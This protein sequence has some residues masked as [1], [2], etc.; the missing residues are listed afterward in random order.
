MDQRLGPFDNL[1]ANLWQWFMESKG[2]KPP[3]APR[4]A[5]IYGDARRGMPLVIRAE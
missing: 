4:G 2:I 1:D 3:E 5:G